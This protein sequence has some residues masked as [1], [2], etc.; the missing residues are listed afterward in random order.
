MS[1]SSPFNDGR[2]NLHEIGADLDN[3]RHVKALAHG[4][5][6]PSA[7]PVVSPDVRGINEA[8]YASITEG[9]GQGDGGEGEG[10]EG[11]REARSRAPDSASPEFRSGA[12]SGLPENCSRD[13]VDAM[14]E[15][16][17]LRLRIAATGAWLT[18][19][20]QPIPFLHDGATVVH[21]LW[22]RVY[23]RIR[24]EGHDR[25]MASGRPT[26]ATAR[27]HLVL[28]RPTDLFTPP[29]EVARPTKSPHGT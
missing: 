18:G 4:V 3:G 29:R 28:D 22:R 10:R 27:F 11:S 6:M 5:L 14:T 9:Q 20:I 2:R 23:L 13:L 16:K 19:R 1:L 7:A 8:G 17:Q 12:L 15:Y 21:Q 26:S 24:A 25:C